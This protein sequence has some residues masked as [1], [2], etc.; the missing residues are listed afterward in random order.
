MTKQTALAGKN[1]L[2]P[3][4]S[5]HPSVK[6]GAPGPQSKQINYKAPASPAAPSKGQ[7]ARANQ[8]GSTSPRTDGGGGV[9]NSADALHR[10]LF[11]K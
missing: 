6:Q 10:S 5:G 8:S 4:T 9:G 1:T 2:M 3:Q 7:T 11:G